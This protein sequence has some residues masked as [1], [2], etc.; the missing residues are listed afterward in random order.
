MASQSASALQPLQSPALPQKG[1]PVIVVTQKQP[2][3]PAQGVGV[4]GSAPTHSFTTAFALPL[5]RPFLQR[6]EQHC[7]SRRHDFFALRQAAPLSPT[8]SRARRTANP[9]PPSIFSALRRVSADPRI[10]ERLSKR[11]SSIVV[12]LGHIAR[13]EQR[14]GS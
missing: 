9:L 7:P 1:S 14:Y 2:L 4:P 12:L 6:P 8:L 13:D 10:R 11:R 5:Q 3:P